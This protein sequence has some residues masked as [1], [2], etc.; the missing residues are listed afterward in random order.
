MLYDP[1]KDYKSPRADLIAWLEKQP[2][3]RTYNWY[4]SS[5]CLMGLY[6]WGTS[7]KWEKLCHW[8]GWS[9]VY[10]FSTFHEPCGSMTDYVY[11]GSTKPWTMGDA[12]HRAKEVENGEIT[13]K[14]VWGIH[15][16]MI[17]RMFV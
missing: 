9:T 6:Y 3:S 1:S 7:S 4:S 2:A 11:I 14:Q 13:S 8:M 16:D 15:A 12:L 5:R 17:E 10:R